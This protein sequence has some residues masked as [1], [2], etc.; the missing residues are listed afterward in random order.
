MT[1]PPRRPLLGS[2]GLASAAAGLWLPHS[3]GSAVRAGPVGPTQG[4]RP[5]SEALQ[6]ASADAA[7]SVVEVESFRRSRGRLRKILDGSEWSSTSRGWW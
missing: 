5:V 7:R 3:G 6:T 4:S 2:L 1:N